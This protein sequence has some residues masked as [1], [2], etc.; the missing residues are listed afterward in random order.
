MWKAAHSKDGCR[1]DGSRD[2]IQHW[3]REVVICLERK[4]GR[5]CIHLEGVLRYVV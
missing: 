1:R 2:G 3:R 4:R 5:L